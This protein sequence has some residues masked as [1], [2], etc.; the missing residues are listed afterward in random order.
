MKN[1]IQEQ[2]DMSDDGTVP[3]TDTDDTERESECD[4]YQG[5]DNNYMG[6]PHNTRLPQFSDNIVNA[7]PLFKHIEPIQRPARAPEVISKDVQN[8]A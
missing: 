7:L 3:N 4:F 1:A 8:L 5:L 6:I 2:G